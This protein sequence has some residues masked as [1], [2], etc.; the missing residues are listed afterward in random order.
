MQIL[1]TGRLRLTP[2]TYTDLPELVRLKADPLVYAQMLGGVRTPVQTAADLAEDQRYWAIHGVG[3]WAVRAGGGLVGLTGLHDRADG[4]SPALRMAFQPAA[5]GHG[6]AR[7]AAGAALR[8]AHAAGI[9]LVYAVAREDNFGS[10]TVL[11]A[12]GMRST[13]GFDRAGQRMMVY[14]SRQNGRD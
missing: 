13:G 6:F 9:E 11:G 14:E 1:N 10:R 4:R 5:R 3:I 2:V 8:H 12:I 7:E